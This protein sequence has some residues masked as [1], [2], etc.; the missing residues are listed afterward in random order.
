MTK[1]GDEKAL[2]LTASYIV[3]KKDKLN[4]IVKQQ[5]LEAIQENYFTETA[6]R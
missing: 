1:S 3:R 4:I 6:W 5:L 2:P